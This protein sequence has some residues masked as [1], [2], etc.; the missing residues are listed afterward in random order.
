MNIWSPLWDYV[1][2]E[3]DYEVHNDSN[4]AREIKRKED[5]RSDDA[6]NIIVPR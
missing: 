3:I 4:Y 5:I 2:E 6:H 1:D